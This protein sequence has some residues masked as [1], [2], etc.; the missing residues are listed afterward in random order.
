MQ[1]VICKDNEWLNSLNKCSR[2]KF[3]NLRFLLHFLT[4]MLFAGISVEFQFVEVV[5]VLLSRP[6]SSAQ[7]IRVQLLQLF[8]IHFFP[9]TNETILG[10]LGQRVMLPKAACLEMESFSH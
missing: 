6:G 2:E 7:L 5:S 4:K 3:G 8:W 10:H 9:H 1:H